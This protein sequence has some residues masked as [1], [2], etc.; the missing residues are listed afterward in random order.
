MQ[1]RVTALRVVANLT[2]VLAAAWGVGAC[3]GGTNTSPDGS[4]E[5]QPPVANT[6][7]LSVRADT[8]RTIVLQGTDPDG[9]PLTYRIVDQPYNGT[10]SGSGDTLTYTPNAGELGTDSFTYQVNDGKL[11]AEYHGFVFIT[12]Q[13]AGYNEPPQPGDWIVVTQPNQPVAIS[14]ATYDADGDELSYAIFTQPAHGTLSGSGSE[15]T[16]TPSKDWIGSDEFVFSVDDGRG[17]A[18]AT[19]TVVVTPK[20]VF[21]EMT[22]E[23]R[24][25]A[26]SQITSRVAAAPA[27]S[28]AADLRALESAV[29]G[30]AGVVF[31]GSDR[32]GVFGQFRDG[33][34]FIVGADAMLEPLTP[35][36]VLPIP[37]LPPRATLDEARAVVAPA[38]WLNHPANPL[39][40]T[41]QGMVLPGSKT[42]L[43][44]SAFGNH[45]DF[46]PDN[47]TKLKAMLD[48][49]GYQT[50]IR[51]NAGI[52][53]FE[54]DGLV[55]VVH[56][57]THGGVGSII[58][59]DDETVGHLEAF[60]TATP[61]SELLR[62]AN[63]AE[64]NSGELVMMNENVSSSAREWHFG[65]TGKFI[66]NHWRLDDAY[67]HASSCTLGTFAPYQ[68]SAGQRYQ[69]GQTGL[70]RAILSR[71]AKLF[72]GWTEPTHV[73]KLDQVANYVFDRMLGE[74]GE[75]GSDAPQETPLQRPMGAASIKRDMSGKGLDLDHVTTSDGSWTSVFRFMKPGGGRYT[76]DRL[77]PSITHL[78]VD[79]DQKKLFV[80]GDLEVAGSVDR[81]ISI[82]G[83]ESPAESDGDGFNCNLP[84][85]ASGDV[86]VIV[87]GR[88]SNRVRLG[89]YS[90]T[91]TYTITGPG[92]LKQVWTFEVKMLGDLHKYRDWAGE[93]PTTH[94]SYL[95]LM[96]DGTRAT[97][98]A[99]GQHNDGHYDVSWSGEGT[100]TPFVSETAT[101][102]DGSFA[103]F[104][105]LNP[106]YPD[107]L[108]W[109][110]MISLSEDKGFR[111]VIKV[112]QPD[113]TWK[114]MNDR[115]VG[116]VFPLDNSG[117][118][119]TQSG[120]GF[121]ALKQPASI[122]TDGSLPDGAIGPE[123]M[124]FIGAGDYTGWSFQ[125][126]FKWSGFTPEQG[127]E[128]DDKMPR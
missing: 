54:I 80:Y 76:V 56:V 103:L 19:V 14:L 22:E 27:L 122:A 7:E 117:M 12:I 24:T 51:A 2:V 86:R 71:G 11:D 118:I 90:G 97:F 17:P 37:Q 99:S 21:G 61:D 8:P 108:W 48:H 93:N 94:K 69:P 75:S 20:P 3:G 120:T 98:N 9:D 13:E 38:A 78:M 29:R 58:N 44:I 15:R 121:F 23:E 110:I 49:A 18:T 116:S 42:A 87:D 127:S 33:V 35:A 4:A 85:G 114:T 45:P 40:M 53:D 16:Y 84:G 30:V 95:R 96:A 92:S 73:A 104:G 106:T 101:P 41:P 39:A 52:L 113:D 60:W 115:Q 89:S 47:S 67:V 81:R 64:L 100:L 1:N 6:F 68:P 66:E 125:H 57:R 88:K 36:P 55:G 91:L 128:I 32:N 72:A 62:A 28:S 79:P 34:A 5:N 111:E 10:L 105:Q 109:N 82:G 63:R 74:D 70:Q 46:P 119:S 123:A 112:K 124:N 43:I 59:T 65:V 102:P 77:A 25:A 50:T 107:N 31:V 26:L 126:E 83:N